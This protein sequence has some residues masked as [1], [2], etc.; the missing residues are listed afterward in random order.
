VPRP[1]LKDPF[2]FYLLRLKNNIVENSE[3]KAT[4]VIPA[5]NVDRCAPYLIAAVKGLFWI[6]FVY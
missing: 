6:Y 2:F 3:Q 1:I 5:A 4:Y